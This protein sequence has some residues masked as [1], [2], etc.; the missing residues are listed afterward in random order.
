MFRKMKIFYKTA[1]F[2]GLQVAPFLAMADDKSLKKTLPT[3]DDL[4]LKTTNDLIAYIKGALD[5][6]FWA[7]GIYA[8]YAVVLAGYKFISSK[9]DPKVVADA[10]KLLLYAIIAFALGLSAKALPALVENFF[11]G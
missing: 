5:W 3:A 6:M 4:K 7:L 11:L 1:I 8:I 9:G 2:A 10:R